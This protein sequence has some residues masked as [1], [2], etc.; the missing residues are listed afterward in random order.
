MNLKLSHKSKRAIVFKNENFS[1]KSVLLEKLNLNFLKV[2]KQ[3]FLKVLSFKYSSYMVYKNMN[4][5]IKE[6]NC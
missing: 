5:K 6:H 2:F 4:C 3:N 1:V